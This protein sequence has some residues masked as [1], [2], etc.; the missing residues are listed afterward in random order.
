MGCI[1]GDLLGDGYSTPIGCAGF[2]GC[3]F[4][5][6][7]AVGG[8]AWTA[9]ASVS[10]DCVYYLCVAFKDPCFSCLATMF[11]YFYTCWVVSIDSFDDS[12]H[13]VCFKLDDVVLASCCHLRINLALD[14]VIVKVF[15][16]AI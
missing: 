5:D 16:A 4:G 15:E 3:G 1:V 7:C 14:D 11:V 13:G 2:L 10:P 12:A 9:R 8:C 6:G